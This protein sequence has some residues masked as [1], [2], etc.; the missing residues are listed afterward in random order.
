MP[1][2]SAL[3][4]H[5]ASRLVS[6]GW[7]DRVESNLADVAGD[8]CPG[9]VVRVERGACV[10]ALADGDHA[11]RST[12]AVAVGDWVGARWRGDA[13]VVEVV[14]ARWSQLARRD[15]GGHRQVLASNIDSV[16]IAA[17]ADRLSAA[18]V[19]RETAMAWDSGA[20][21]VVLLTKL[22]LAETGLVEGLRERLLGVEV[23]ATSVVTGAGMERVAALL[24]PAR[25]GV[26]LGPSGA[27]KSS[28]IN[29]L[30]GTPRLAV[31]DVRAGDR[32]GRHTTSVRQLLAVPGGGVLI[33]TPGL[34]SLA[35]AG[36]DG[37]AV[38]F[39]DIE[40]LA[41][42]CRFADCRHE[43]EPGCAVLAA[44]EAGQLDPDR[45]ANYHK[46]RR[47]LDFQ[48]RRG[49]PVARAEAERIWKIRAK[50]TRRLFRDRERHQE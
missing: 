29:V 21:P 16:F 6:L 17:P 9:R 23:I 14:A 28:L 7:D 5:S 44:A 43:C 40:D 38:T 48:A 39:A 12:I 30:V 33:D 4:D 19:E 10:V 36:A 8:L 15:P 13:L 1:D 27:G 50:A 37:V 2:N 26:L 41:S 45:V 18:R 22:D 46:L 3:F 42:G 11:A 49:D 47:E 31:G 35:L 24:R 25:T 32:R 34:R 20:Q